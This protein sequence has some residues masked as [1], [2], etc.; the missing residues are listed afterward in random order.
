MGN[1]KHS[2]HLSQWQKSFSKYEME[3][4]ITQQQEAMQQQQI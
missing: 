3:S 4:E 1:A 2:S